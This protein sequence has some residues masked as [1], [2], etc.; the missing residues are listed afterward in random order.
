MLKSRKKIM[1][2]VFFGTMSILFASSTCI[3]QDGG[4]SNPTSKNDASEM[5]KNGDL[6]IHQ[7]FSFT[8]CGLDY[9]FVSKKVTDRISYPTGTGLPCGMTISGIPAGA[10][11]VKSLLYWTITVDVSGTPNFSINGQNGVANLIGTGNAK[12]WYPSTLY[13]DPSYSATQ[14]LTQDYR[15]DVTAMVTGNGNYSV[16]LTDWSR[17]ID[18][19]GIIVVYKQP[20]TA[21]E[22]T[23]VINDGCKTVDQGNNTNEVLPTVSPC[24][25][26]CFVKTFNI[27]SDFATQSSGSY[28][29]YTMNGI[30][31]QVDDVFYQIDE[32][33]NPFPLPAGTQTISYNIKSS[34]YANSTDCFNLEANGLYFR[35]YSCSSCA[36][37]F[38]P[39]L[40]VNDA[41]CGQCDGSATITANGGTSPYSVQWNPSV[42]AGNNLFSVSSLCEGDYSVTLSDNSGCI[43][44]VDSFSVA[45]TA[46]FVVDSVTFNP[47]PCS[48]CNGNID[49]AISNPTGTLTYNLTMVGGTTT[50]QTNNGYFGSLCAG[51]YNLSVVDANGCD[52]AEVIVIQQ[53]SNVAIDSIQIT[54]DNGCAGNCNGTISV[55]P[56]TGLTYS[57][58]GGSNWQNTSVFNQVCAANYT[59]MIQDN[60]GCTNSQTVSIN[61]SPLQL[62]NGQDTTICQN[63]SATL[64]ITISGGQ[65]PYTY[66]WNP[67][68]TNT[69]NIIVSPTA[70]QIYSVSVTDA[71]GCQSSI[72]N[73]N[74]TVLPPISVS[75]LPD[76]HYCEGIST[77]LNTTVTGGT[78]NYQYAWVDLAS[79]QILGTNS[80][81]TFTH[82]GTGTV[83]LIVKDDCST[84]PDTVSFNYFEESQPLLNLTTSNSIGCPP[85]STSLALSNVPSGATINWNIGG[86]TFNSAPS[87]LDFSTSTVGC[88]DV[89]ATIT[90]TSGCIFSN[91]FNQ[92]FCVTPLPNALFQYSPIEPTTMNSSIDLI[93]ASDYSYLP[94]WSISSNA[95]ISDPTVYNPTINYAFTQADSIHVCLTVT[96][97]I[98]CM[99]DICTSIIVENEFLLYVPNSFTPDGDDFNQ[100]FIPV[101]NI[102]PSETYQ[103]MIF[104]RWGNM[105][106]E[107]KDPTKG[108]DGSYLGK[109]AQDGTYTW[110][111]VMTK[112]SKTDG[113]QLFVGHVNLLK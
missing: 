19:I 37:N 59:V 56:T 95:H 100:E 14:L 90:T 79:Q 44:F 33:V 65:I 84:T 88:Q 1:F 18:G 75:S 60:F 64:G 20:G 47:T 43:T 12:C 72:S 78:G 51:T 27:V 85:F 34:M 103:F 61:A 57:I 107:S 45:G 29:Y 11:I 53:T 82:S 40:V 36:D 35:T 83:L 69:P 96:D 104:N 49:V 77:L 108:W 109:R 26:A 41:S 98:G 102:D 76:L 91:T 66:N 73:F 54:V 4:I 55:F 25:D 74:V 38:Q 13:D 113:N 10:V 42:A 58:N 99:A 39:N 23:L 50:T 97:T 21:W 28:H 110:K 6:S 8:D 3:G 101:T 89:V 80:T 46:P 92:V 5:E 106:F 87:T 111:I 7:S 30:Q 63:G 24:V 68:N 48:A 9:V 105:I 32:I 93:Y 81:L 62:S 16:N 71:L 70:T 86:Q 52:Y 67:V 94:H 112:N 31:H 2:G 22:G 15:A 17:L